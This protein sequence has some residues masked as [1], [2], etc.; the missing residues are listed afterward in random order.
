MLRIFN[1]LSMQEKKALDLARLILKCRAERGLSL[2]AFGKAAG[3]SAA[4]LSK[5]ERGLVKPNRATEL[6]LI[7]LLTG[8]GYW[9]RKEAA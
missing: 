7:A 9:P 8:F 2:V 6:R 4:G 3:L 1:M 5:I